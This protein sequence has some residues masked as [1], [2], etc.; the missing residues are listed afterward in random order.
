MDKEKRKDLKDNEKNNC[1]NDGYYD[2]NK[3]KDKNKEL[4]KGDTKKKK[5]GGDNKTN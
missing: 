1:G 5:N 2:K 4:K 3:L